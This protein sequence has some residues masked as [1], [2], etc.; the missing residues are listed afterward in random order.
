LAGSSSGQADHAPS[1]DLGDHSAVLVAD[2]DLQSGWGGV[3]QQPVPGRLVVDLSFRQPGG[4]SCKAACAV[5]AGR[6][7]AFQ[8]AKLQEQLLQLG[9]VVAGLL[10]GL[11]VLEA[12]A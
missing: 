12:V 10:G 6:H 8:L 4:P 2:D 11:L 5:V 7:G 3:D 1:P 9:L